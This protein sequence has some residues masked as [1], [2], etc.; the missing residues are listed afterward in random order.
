LHRV[1]QDAEEAVM[2]RIELVGE[3]KGKGRPRFMR[4]T[5]HT[6][7]PEATRSYEAALRYAA[8]EAMAGRPLLGGALWL[9]VAAWVPIPASWS[10]RRQRQ[11]AAGLI[12]PTTRPD[13]D[14]YLK[15]LDALNKVVW[16][17]D[18]Q[19]VTQ[20]FS[21]FYSTQPKLVV[22]VETLDEQRA[23]ETAALAKAAKVAA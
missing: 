23:I 6:Y 16:R 18:A 10:G 15:A 20:S 14:N 7:T 3:P 17:D 2:I 21:K 9:D 13:F 22:L 5:G 1:R 4:A 8:Q 19:I 12:R 11:A